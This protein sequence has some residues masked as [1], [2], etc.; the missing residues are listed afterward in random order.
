MIGNRPAEMSLVQ[1]KKPYVWLS[2]E[3]DMRT[4]SQGWRIFEI[5]FMWPHKLPPEGY[6]FTAEHYRGFVWRFAFW[7]PFETV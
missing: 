4:L 3:R 6:Y 1:L 2:I 7:L 5:A